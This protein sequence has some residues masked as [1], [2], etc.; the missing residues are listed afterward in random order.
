MKTTLRTS[1]LLVAILAMPSVGLSQVVTLGNWT[2]FGGSSP[3]TGNGNAGFTLGNGVSGFGPD[4]DGVE[5]LFTPQTL[6]VGET[7]IFSFQLDVNVLPGD[8][9][10]ER[11]FRFGL[12]GLTDGGPT[13]TYGNFNA[14]GGTLAGGTN[15]R[16]GTTTAPFAAGTEA[17][18]NSGPVPPSIEIAEGNIINFRYEI[19]HVS[20][21]MYD[22]SG[23]W[24]VGDPNELS[25]ELNGV[26]LIDQ[27][28][29][30]VYIVFNPVNTPFPTSS[31]FIVSG[32]SV[33]VV[34][35]PTSFAL[36]AS[37]GLLLAVRRRRS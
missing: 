32:A 8:A 30:E 25:L 22:L 17:V 26:E 10:Y 7:M 12:G 28:F 15:S 29:S 3:F 1:L 4:A 11:G 31:E 23:F 36:L 37:A 20:T 35:E 33:T 19:E 2:V 6:A 34:P 24:G 9:S 13:T 18:S 14:D 27:V 16:L 5:S 21:N